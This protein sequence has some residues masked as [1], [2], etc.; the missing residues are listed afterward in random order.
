MGVALLQQCHDIGHVLGFVLRDIKNGD[1]AIRAL[2]QVQVPVGCARVQQ[3]ADHLI[4]HLHVREGERVL[5]AP[6]RLLGRGGALLLLIG[7]RVEKVFESAHHDAFSLDPVA[8]HGERL[9][10]RGLA[11]GEHAGVEAIQE[12]WDHVLGGFCIR[13]LLRGLRAQDT[14]EA[15]GLVLLSMHWPSRRRIAV[16]ALRSVKDERATV[17]EQLHRVANTAREL[18]RCFGTNSVRAGLTASNE[19]R[20]VFFEM[21]LQPRAI[22]PVLPHSH[23]D[24]CLTHRSGWVGHA[25]S[26]NWGARYVFLR[27]R[28]S[29]SAGA[30][31]ALPIRGSTQ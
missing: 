26:G 23:K 17:I 14:V 25:L 3:I 10:R 20:V 16:L 28:S 19:A 8:Q 29:Q 4:V 22:Q 21:Q 27:A 5:H 15:E 12:R 2:A 7:Q 11:I 9:A 31:G 30:C 24:V 18:S 1:I 13:L 6:A